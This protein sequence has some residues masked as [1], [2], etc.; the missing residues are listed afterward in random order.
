MRKI[1][2]GEKKR[3]KKKRK[4]EKKKKIMTFIGATTS[5]PVNRP[6]ADRAGTPH[7]R[8]NYGVSRA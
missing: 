3:K 8:A 6:N 5:L 2:D 4:K 7:A 1:D